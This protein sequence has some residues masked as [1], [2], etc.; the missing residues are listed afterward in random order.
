[1]RK[2][3]PLLL[4]L[5]MFLA[6]AIIAGYLLLY[7]NKINFNSSAHGTLIH[8]PINIGLV[9]KDY[10]WHVVYVTPEVCDAFCEQQQ[11]KLNK[12]H[13]ALGVDKN[14]VAI[15]MLTKQQLTF[16]I[17]PA[18]SIPANNSILIVNPRGLYIMHYDTKS[19][20]MGLLQDLKKLL[21][22]S[23]ARDSK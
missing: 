22:Y 8:S 14:R 10:K 12:V 1:M 11:L 13:T 5:S 4:M 21:K 7:S 23:H 19:D 2:Q 9:T 17:T 3:W 20:Y 6:P 18:T 16:K 15:T